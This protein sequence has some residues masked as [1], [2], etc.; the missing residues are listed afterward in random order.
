MGF[1]MLGNGCILT[2]NVDDVN[3][4]QRYDVW[5]FLFY[6]LCALFFSLFSQL[7]ML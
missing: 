5:Q 1:T 6:F 4:L 2:V 3:K 7:E